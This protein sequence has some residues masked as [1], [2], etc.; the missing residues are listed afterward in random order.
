MAFTYPLNDRAST[1]T[2][3]D[4]TLDRQQ[5]RLRIG[6][7]DANRPLWSDAQ[8]DAALT[9]KGSVV[10]ACLFL[11]RARLALITRDAGSVNAAGIST[12][13]E[14]ADAL[15]QVIADLQMDAVAGV[16]LYA[17]G[18][19]LTDRETDEADA[20]LEQPR[21]NVRRWNREVIE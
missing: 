3:S 14:E 1:A 6:D 4:L 21:A 11:C 10:G 17:G 20:S 19:L 9:A 7:Y 8:I 15:R 5:V 16:G 18:A 2:E 13:R 12:S